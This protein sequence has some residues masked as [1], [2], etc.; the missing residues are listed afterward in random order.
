[1]AAISRRLPLSN[2]FVK[3]LIVGGIG[4]LINQFMLFMLYDSPT[5]WFLPAQD[6]RLDLG[7]F[8][9]PDIR[10][11]I[12]SVLAVETAIVF[13]FNAHERWTFRDRGRKGWGPIR[14]LKFN[15]GAGVSSIIVVVTVNTLTPLV[16]ISPY[17]SNTIGIM[18]GFMWNWTWNTLIIWPQH[19]S[20]RK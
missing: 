18:I 14:F 20:G 11:L 4:F 9:H 15:L 6:T 5:F 7:L 13:Q 10:L 17:L 2:T 8:R 12:S 1:V 3:F 19:Q 16:R